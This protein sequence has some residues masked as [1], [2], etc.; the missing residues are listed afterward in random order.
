MPSGST[1]KVRIVDQEW[2][3]HSFRAADLDVQNMTDE[4]VIEHRLNPEQERAFRTI[5]NH[6]SCKNPERLQMYLGG[7]GGT[8]K[9]EV[10]KALA[11]FFER[12]HESHL[13]LVVAPTG[14]A[15]SLLNG[16]TYHSTFGISDFNDGDRANLRND[17]AT[18]ARL[19]GVDYVFVDETSMLSCRDLYLISE[20]ACRAL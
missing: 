10:L 5:A 17:A 18:K 14:S 2:L 15:A 11:K 3:Q 12:R 9:S 20:S 4:L 19:M 7:M 13:F 6:A 1:N 8:G 16:T